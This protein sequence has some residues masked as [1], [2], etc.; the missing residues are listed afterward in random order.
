MNGVMVLVG[1][2]RVTGPPSGSSKWGRLEV[3]E[4]RLQ[5]EKG[6]RRQ[7]NQLHTLASERNVD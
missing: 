7:D 1:K 5:G 6:E 2:E 4:L 3:D